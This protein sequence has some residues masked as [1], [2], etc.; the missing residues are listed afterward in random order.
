MNL[1]AKK[2]SDEDIPFIYHVFEQNRALLHES[3]I[4]LEEWTKHLAGTDTSGGGDP[5]ESHHIIM[6]GATPA[7][8]LKIHSWNKPEICI[9]MLV[10]EDSFKHKGV[11]S[12][13]IKFAEKQARYWAKSAIRIQTTKDNVIA[14]ECYLKCGYEIVREIE[15]YKGGQG[16]YEFKKAIFPKALTEDNLKN[17]LSKMLNAQ[18]I[19]VDFQT[20]QLQGGTVGDVRLVTGMAETADGKKTPYKII[21]K[22]QKKWE[23]HGDYDSWRREYDLYASDFADLFTGSLRWPKCCHAEINDDEF[24]LWIEY[25]DGISGNGLTIETLEYAATELGRFQGRVFKQQDIMENIKCMSMVDTIIKDYG[26]WKPETVEYQYLY[27]NECTL[28]EHL[29]RMLIDTQR[30]AETVF[31]KIKRLPVVLCHK[32]FWI[33]NIFLSDQEIILIDW[34]GTGWGYL[35]E[36]IASLIVDD[37]DVELLDEYYRRLIPAYYKGLSE[38]MDVSTIESHYIREMIIIKFG[39]RFLQKFM[40]AGS[41]DVKNRQITA[42]QK[43]YE[44]REIRW[45]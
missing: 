37:T 34:D 41:S 17:A 40:F 12:F 10:V 27:S 7:A 24:A 5:Y 39:Y 6:A 9:S 45:N 13:A 36:D 44:M 26:Q 25:I 11:G 21:L 28:P 33:E 30:Q 16:G 20:E 31:A 1:S 4:S 32:D 8:W 14:T 19:R 38:S 3:Y 15:N 23:R 42:L 22:V 35:G 43:I 18:I 29:R 2:M